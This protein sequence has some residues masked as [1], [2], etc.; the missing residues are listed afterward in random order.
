M[1][2]VS[3]CGDIAFNLMKGR[4]HPRAGY[5]DGPKSSLDISIRG[6]SIVTL[7]VST[8]EVSIPSAIRPGQS[9]AMTPAAR[10]T[11]PDRCRACFMRWGTGSQYSRAGR[12]T[13]KRP[14]R[15]SRD[16]DAGIRHIVVNPPSANT[17]AT[18]GAALAPA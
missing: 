16:S 2:C 17:L 10:G 9:I 11:A 5:F 14:N 15:A 13:E 18:T 7:V 1:D 8:T 12:E 6:M 3:S 4:P